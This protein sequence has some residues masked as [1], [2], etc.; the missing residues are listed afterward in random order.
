MTASAGIQGPV[1]PSVIKE[2]T[3]SGHS[4]HETTSLPLS[5]LS[6]PRNNLMSL[7]SLALPFP[8]SFLHPLCLMG[9]A[10]P[11]P[12]REGDGLWGC[13]GA[14]RPSNPGRMR[15]AHQSSR[16]DLQFFFF[17]NCKSLHAWFLRQEK[18]PNPFAN[19]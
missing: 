1:Y 13:P 12:T 17:W 15:R 8:A 4:N 6:L 16:T 19:T 7:L 10:M 9:G 14:D 3:A 2:L 5:A 18:T 11:Q